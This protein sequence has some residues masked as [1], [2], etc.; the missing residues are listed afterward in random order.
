MADSAA[1]EVNPIMV[2]M[3]TE[4]RYSRLGDGMLTEKG[5]SRRYCGLGRVVLICLIVVL[6][7]ALG[8]GLRA[9]LGVGLNHTTAK[10][11]V[12]LTPSSGAVSSTVEPSTSAAAT[13]SSAPTSIGSRTSSGYST[14]TTTTTATTRAVSTTATQANAD[15]SSYAFATDTSRTIIS[16]NVA[17]TASVATATDG[18]EYYTIDT[19]YAYFYA[20]ASTTITDAATITPLCVP[21]GNVLKE[22]NF[23]SHKLEDWTKGNTVAAGDIE[24]AEFERSNYTDVGAYM[25]QDLALSSDVDYLLR[26]SFRVKLFADWDSNDNLVSFNITANSYTPVSVTITIPKNS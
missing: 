20:T 5:V 13:S 26:Y 7:V 21:N 24:T 1:P 16:S 6:I 22:P 23:D 4:P 8:V 17:T 12:A 2:L 9:G 11:S 14:T 3:V 18:L 19:N 15:A 25:Y 10:G